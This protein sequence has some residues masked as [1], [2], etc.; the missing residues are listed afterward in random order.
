V[1]LA[2]QFLQL[3]TSNSITIMSALS[4]SQELSKNFKL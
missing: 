1:V 2:L 3:M 4:K